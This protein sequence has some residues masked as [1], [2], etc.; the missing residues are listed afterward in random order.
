MSTTKII[1]LE[2][3]SLKEL[4]EAVQALRYEILCCAV[5]DS[6]QGVSAQNYLFSQFP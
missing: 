2:N 4:S 6:L 3:A 1:D 5:G